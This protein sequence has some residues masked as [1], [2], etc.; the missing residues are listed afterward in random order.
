M[1]PNNI[2]GEA[3]LLL[4][5]GLTLVVRD[6]GCATTSTYYD[7]LIGSLLFIFAAIRWMEY[8]AAISDLVTTARI[9]VAL[10]WGIPVAILVWLFCTRGGGG[11]SGTPLR[12]DLLVFMIASIIGLIMTTVA[13]I[14]GC[15]GYAMIRPDT[16]CGSSC[17]LFQWVRTDGSNMFMS[18]A[19]YI[20]L[21][22][23][24]VYLVLF[25]AMDYSFWIIAFTAA[26]GMA[27][28][29]AITSQLGATCHSATSPTPKVEPL[30]TAGS[31]ATLVMI[32]VG[33][34]TILLAPG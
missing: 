5:L 4:I 11:S 28:G 22:A 25:S 7:T 20:F 6:R 17:G 12:V 21:F 2:F 3:I 10:A 30:A 23:G 19:F 14:M 13:L 27:L 15:G 32:V 24:L 18:P 26:F 9:T 34:V 33:V 31:L 29:S 16:T 1:H 8:G